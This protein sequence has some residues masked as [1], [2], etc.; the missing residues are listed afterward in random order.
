MRT[1]NKKRGDL[2]VTE[3][4]K[5]GWE[6]PKETYAETELWREF[7]EDLRDWKN[8]TKEAREKK[9]LF[10]RGYARGLWKTKDIN[11]VKFVEITKE[12]RRAQEFDEDLKEILFKIEGV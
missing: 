7:A 1:A 2:K 8:E 10:Y 5:K 11:W 9:I 12:L 3:I 6:M 4:I